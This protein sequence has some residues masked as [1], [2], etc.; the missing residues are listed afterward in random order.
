MT[1]VIITHIKFTSKL[2]IRIFCFLL[3]NVFFVNAQQAPHYAQ[4]FYNMQVLNPAFVGSKSD[5]NAA[6]LTRRQWINV[7]G[8]PETSTFSVNT[9]INSGFGFGATVISDKI[10]LVDNTS[11]NFDVSYTIPTSEFGRLSFGVKSGVAF[12]NNDL[13][14]GI[15][16]DDEVYASTT[17]QYGNLGFGFLY[18]SK[19]FYVGLSSQNLF[20]SPVFRLQDDIQTVRG[21]ERGN[22]FFTGGMSIELSK[23]NDVVF[24]PSTM[25][26]YT[27]TLPVSLDINANFIFNKKYEIGASYRHQNSLS[28]MVSLIVNE[29]YRIGYAYENYLSSI[30]QNL[31][32]HELILRIDL[33]LERNKRWL[34]L[35]CCYF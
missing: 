27:P 2:K 23:F 6:L 35:D 33:K 28:A 7:E 5:L 22:Y 1:N 9:R 15:T 3:L 12:F 25:I 30:G 4:Y 10:G 31:N 19:D 20:E 14:S 18:S 34:N 13:A 8:A 29:K 32:S 26:K 21:L 17:G 11:L 16:V 24:R